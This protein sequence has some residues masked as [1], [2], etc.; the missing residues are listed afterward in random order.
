LHLAV[1]NGTYDVIQTLFQL[2][3]EK[4]NIGDNLKELLNQRNTEGDTTLHI[5]E[6]NGKETI[7]NF[8]RSKGGEKGLDITIKNF[9]GSTADDCKKRVVRRN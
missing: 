2:A 9:N 5:A 7:S 4:K 3:D 6:M 8:L 1:L